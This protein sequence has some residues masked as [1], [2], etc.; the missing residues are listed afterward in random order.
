MNDIELLLK[1]VSGILSA[2]MVVTGFSVA[3]IKPFRKKFKRWIIETASTQQITD[4]VRATGDMVKNLSKEISN[5]HKELT[6]HI[7][8]NSADIKQS[9]IAQTVTLRLQLR[10]IYMRN[11]DSKTLSER[12]WQDVNDIY[13][14][15][16]SFG[17][18]KYAHKMH[19]E[20]MEWEIRDGK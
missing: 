3:L 13:D 7:L 8:E 10:E 14:V 12:E 4:S 20:M 2:I 19:E 16:T 11:F 9:T 5:L 1:S 17:G 6:Q 18:N 15:Y